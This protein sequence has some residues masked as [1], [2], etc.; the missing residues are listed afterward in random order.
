MSDPIVALSMLAIFLFIIL[1]GF[2]VAF[3]L[4]AM[5]IGPGAAGLVCCATT[6]ALCWAMLSS[7]F[8]LTTKTCTREFSAPMLKARSADPIPRSCAGSAGRAGGQSI[9]AAFRRLC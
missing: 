2:P 6:A 1:L 9:L 4:M 5:G 8:V 3:T 7:S